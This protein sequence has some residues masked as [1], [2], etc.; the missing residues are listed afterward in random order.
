ML[1]MLLAYENIFFLSLSLLFH[2]SRARVRRHRQHPPPTPASE[3]GE[4]DQ[5]AAGAEG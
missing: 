1:A 4:P 3:A 2:Q 5:Q